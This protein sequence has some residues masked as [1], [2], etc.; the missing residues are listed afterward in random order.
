MEEPDKEAVGGVAVS[1]VEFC[2][3]AALVERRGGTLE[4]LCSGA[5]V[6]ADLVLTAASCLRKYVHSLKKLSRDQIFY[7]FANISLRYQT[8]Q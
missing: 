5:L 4:Y 2:W 1:T 7:H 3:V 8:F 6:E